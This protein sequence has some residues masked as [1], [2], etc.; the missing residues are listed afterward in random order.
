MAA[1]TVR[2]L[3]QA[4]PEGERRVLLSR[5]QKSLQLNSDSESSIYHGKSD[6]NDQA[7]RIQA[8]I[9]KLGLWQRIV[10]FFKKLFSSRTEQE[11]FMSMKVD[12]LFKRLQNKGHHLVQLEGRWLEPAF[13]ELVYALYIQILPLINVFRRFWK[14]PDKLQGLVEFILERR[15][16]NAKSS[17]FRFM[18]FQELQDYFE[19]FESKE[20][21]KRELLKRIEIYLENI[22]PEVFR[23]IEDGIFP[24]YYYKELVLFDFTHFF[25]AFQVDIHSAVSGGRIEFHAAKADPMLEQLEHLYY[26]L[27]AARRAQAVSSMHEEVFIYFSSVEEAGSGGR[28]EAPADMPDSPFENEM[29]PPESSASE[30]GF[31]ETGGEP[32]A[33][34]DFQGSSGGAAQKKLFKEIAGAVEQ[35]WQKAQL[36]NIIRFFR[37]NPYYRF[38]AYAPNLSIQDFYLS[39][40]RLKVL[41]E[42][43]EQF[44]NVRR[45]VIRKKKERIFPHN[46]QDFE[47]YRRSVISSSNVKLPVF[48]YVDSIATLYHFLVYR[49]E[50]VHLEAL[51]VLA[52]ILP[53]RFRDYGSRLILSIAA[54]ED[55]LESIR[56]FDYS[57]SPLSDEGKSFYRLRY[58]AEKDLTQLKS[59]RVVV[60]QKDKE[61]K[62]Y[63]DKGVDQLHTLE[64]LMDKIH[65]AQLENLN[66]RFQSLSSSGSG[67]LRKRLETMMNEVKSIQKILFYERQLEEEAHI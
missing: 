13:A 10:L 42:L 27:Y 34:M 37:K 63:L 56:T 36:G 30:T 48:R 40:L 6:S 29:D 44:S 26:A 35:F 7:A 18:T 5:I 67:H 1:H 12:Q 28:P 2:E 49:F 25:N 4:L 22:P 60:A 52:R 19:K 8:D 64:K 66:D 45:E 15:V 38:I 41:S 58:A 54:L 65:D 9:R 33:S 62:G 55:L 51:R 11:L 43:D 3:A 31:R 24:L 23:E 61:V 16:P 21:L 57:F 50:R 53:E 32:P 39:A 17:I 46:M 20:S 47:F 14:A 59:Y